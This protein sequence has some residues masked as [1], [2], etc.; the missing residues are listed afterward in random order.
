MWD[1]LI[2]RTLN[3][4]GHHHIMAWLPLLSLSCLKLEKG[5]KPTLQWSTVWWSHDNKQIGGGNKNI[6]HS[7]PKL[8]RAVATDI[9]RSVERPSNI[10]WNQNIY[11]HGPSGLT[12]WGHLLTNQVWPSSISCTIT[13]DKNTTTS[14][15]IMT[16][17]HCLYGVQCE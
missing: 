16:S 4:K 15:A 17:H 3:W 7:H 12:H 2:S 11:W 14:A 6:H 5:Q 9:H 10:H 8:D 1:G 13:N